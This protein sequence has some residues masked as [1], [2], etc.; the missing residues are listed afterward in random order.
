[1][2]MWKRKVNDSVVIG[3]DI[4][5]AVTGVHPKKGGR[6]EGEVTL[7]FETPEGTPVQRAETFVVSEPEPFPQFY[8]IREK[9]SG[10]LVGYALSPP[11]EFSSREDSNVYELISGYEDMD[12]EL[13]RRV[14]ILF[15]RTNAEAEAFMLALSTAQVVGVELGTV[16][17]KRGNVHIVLID[18]YVNL[19]YLDDP[20]PVIRSYVY[21]SP[22][23]MAA[24]ESLPQRRA[25]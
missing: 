1:M 9:G 5:V 21:Q 23:V 2:I 7:G 10:R 4:V 15:F 19:D 13:D 6:F 3:D 8:R 12:P 22:R 24:L 20:N 16:R 25:G 18:F 17:E 14:D 11:G